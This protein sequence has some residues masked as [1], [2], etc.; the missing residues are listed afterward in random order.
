MQ[1]PL[2]I[3]EASLPEFDRFYQVNVKG[4]F[5]CVQAVSKAMKS[6]DRVSVTGRSGPRDI[7]R[8][9]IINLGSANSFIA[10]PNIVQY[11]AAKHAIMGI[12]KNAG[13]WL[14]V[15]VVSIHCRQF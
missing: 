5:L 6:Q 13:K 12:T 9:V 14:F 1:Q 2:E 3:A 8:G 15:V 7:G 10:T 4:T 11:T